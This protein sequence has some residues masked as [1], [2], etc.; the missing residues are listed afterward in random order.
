MSKSLMKNS[1]YNVIY[2]FF[3]VIF[4]LVSAAYI[5][6]IL[7]VSG[8]GRVA[9][10]QNIVQ[11]F[12]ILAGLGMGSYGTRSVAKY[13]DDK[14]LQNKVFSELFVINAVSTIICTVAY[15]CLILNTDIFKSEL[16][17]Y[18][19]I[20]ILIVFNMF[21]VDW[22]YQ[23]KEEYKYIMIRSI[24]VKLISLI[25]LFIF[26]RNP[27]DYIVY[28]F[29]TCL[30]MIGNNIFNMINLKKYV[31]F[32]FRGLEI[33]KHLKPVFILLGS[34]IAIELY[35]MLDTTMLSFLKSE[36]EVGYYAN[37]VKII[38]MVSNCIIAI[39]AVMLPRMSY[40][41]RNENET[42]LRNISA[43]IFNTL[44]IFSVPATIGVFLLSYNIVFVMFG[45]DF[46]GG[47]TTL[48]ITSIL[49]LVFSIA[50][51][52]AAQVL[53]ASNKEDK[54]FISVCC[55]A[56]INIILNIL[57]IM[58]YNQ[59][60]AAIASVVSEITVMSVQ[61]FFGKKIIKNIIKLRD[62]LSI[63]VATMSMFISVIMIKF[64]I[65]D[66][67][68][69]LVISTGVAIIVYFSILALM[70]N[71]YM[72]NFIEKIYDNFLEKRQD[73]SKWIV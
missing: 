62:V 57:L 29:I 70:K 71:R 48:K 65:K 51:G 2:R 66:I 53:I 42:E 36:I 16:K 59:N 31:S 58:P 67:F 49:I 63:L 73:K 12:V 33:V 37:T 61:L 45:I 50:G 41:Y 6:R 39:G 69:E 9:S 22:F 60:G 44:L 13:R 55:G 35:T 3:N 19:V 17:L 20:G 56:I 32:T 34:T 11:Y 8:V 64:L 24:V 25:L 52:Y 54:Y 28:A 15:Y 40:Y 23:G 30:G 10:A 46:I 43:S 1:F 27:G 72:M 5:A 18:L 14:R 4:P 26:V 47:V 21:N 68:I 38:R 7:S